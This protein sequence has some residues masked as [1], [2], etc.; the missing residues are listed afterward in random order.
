MKLWASQNI[1]ADLFNK[2]FLK[3]GHILGK[4]LCSGPR[5]QPGRQV[6]G[7]TGLAPRHHVR[8]PRYFLLVGLINTSRTSLVCAKQRVCVHP[9]EPRRR[10]FER[11]ARSKEQ[12]F[13]PRASSQGSKQLNGLHAHVL[14]PRDRGTG[15]AASATAATTQTAS[16]SPRSK[17]G[18]R[19]LYARG[20]R[21][22]RTSNCNNFGKLDWNTPMFPGRALPKIPNASQS[23]SPA[24]RPPPAPRAFPLSAVTSAC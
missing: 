20:F 13:N 1:F 22:S 2:P 7:G 10:S 18:I 9:A 24:G 4:T 15:Q 6:H 21:D 14:L 11:T 19:G 23:P 16:V 12:R 3:Y 5:R 17:H 8:C